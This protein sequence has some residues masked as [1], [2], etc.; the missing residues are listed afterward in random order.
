TYGGTALAFNPAKNSL[1][2]VGHDHIQ[3]V[4][5]IEIPASVVN[6]GNL[7][8][9]PTARVLQPFVKV[10]ARIPNY[11]LEGT[12]K[13]GGLMVVDGQLVGTLYV[14]YDGPGTAV[15]SHFRLDS[16]DLARAK[17]E[18]LFT[19]GTLGAGFVAGY[20]APVPAE[21]QEELGAPYVTGQAALAVIGRTSSG[22]ALFGFDPK[23]LG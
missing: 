17:V 5:E 7:S 19:A 6:S 21:L 22:P 18:G 8:D 15:Q 9:L 1:F 23:D 13:V 3:A 4:A 2:L 16:L 12:V 14:Y 10:A 11:K 20:M